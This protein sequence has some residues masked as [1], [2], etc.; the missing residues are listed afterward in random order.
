MRD[1]F[2]NANVDLDA[3]LGLLLKKLVQTV[4]LRVPWG[5]AQ[6]E[7]GREPPIRDVDG[8]CRLLERYGY[9]PEIVATIDIPLDQ[10]SVSLRKVR[11]E[12]VLL[13][14]VGSL[15][16]TALLV[17]FVVSVV[18]V[19]LENVCIRVEARNSFI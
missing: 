6:E 18:F 15:G 17:L 4:L 10:I 7:L 3:L 16:V 5:T 12:A 13:G 11:S 2:V 1:L 14:N 8:L 19:E 9:G